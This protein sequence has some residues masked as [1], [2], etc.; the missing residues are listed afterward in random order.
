MLALLSKN[1]DTT[2][3]DKDSGESSF[4]LA[5]RYGYATN[6]SMQVSPTKWLE[7]WVY[8]P[9]LWSLCCG[10]GVG[11]S[12]HEARYIVR[13]SIIGYYICSMVDDG[14]PLSQLL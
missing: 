7:T 12:R 9:E 14:K 6:V 10:K 13:M 1:A 11:R 2:I 5:A 4:H 3:K 8:S